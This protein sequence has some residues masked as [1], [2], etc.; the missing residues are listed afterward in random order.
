M[1]IIFL[2]AA[3]AAICS[4]SPAINPH[5]IDGWEAKELEFPYAAGIQLLDPFNPGWCG[6]ALISA[7]YV[8]T[9]AKCIVG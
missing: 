2:L 6:G 7:N 8:L 5:I 3:T 4:A 9:A 1:K